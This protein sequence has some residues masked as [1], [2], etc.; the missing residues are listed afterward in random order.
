MADDSITSGTGNVEGQPTGGPVDGQTTVEG[1]GNVE[2]QSGVVEGQGT[3][4]SGTG[5]GNEDTFFDPQSLDGKPELQAAYKQMQRAFSKKMEDIKGHREKIDAYDAFMSDPVK[6]MQRLAGQMGYQLSRAEAAA[7]ANENSASNEPQ[8]WDDVYNTAEQ[9]AYDRLKQEIGPV[10][11]QVNDMRQSNMERL[12]DDNCPDWRVYEDEMTSNLKKHP[13]LAN[14]PVSLYRLSVPS[15][16]LESRATQ[17]ALKKMEGK[18]QS[19]QVSGG[20][21]TNKQPQPGIPN[22]PMSFN[23]AVK[24]A[25]AKLAEEGVRLAT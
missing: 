18:A 22:K 1:T 2:G 13:S 9:R 25:K 20:S 6:E 10:L 5:G 3:T 8:T 7:I 4:N 11:N 12:L 14:D 15:D 23:D 21:T 16:V 24:A 17:A 19:A